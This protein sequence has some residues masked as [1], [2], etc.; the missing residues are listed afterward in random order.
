MKGP[1]QTARRESAYIRRIPIKKVTAWALTGVLFV[2]SPGFSSYQAFAAE[3]SEKP[4]E[5]SSL[6]IP[7]VSVS[8]PSENSAASQDLAIEKIDSLPPSETRL[9]VGRETNIPESKSQEIAAR[10]VQALAPAAGSKSE[11][12][13]SQG[14]RFWGRLS[15]QVFGKSQGSRKIS[16]GVLNRLFDRQKEM[17]TVP[18]SLHSPTTDV[19]SADGGRNIS[20]GISK[21]S[22]KKRLEWVEHIKALPAPFLWKYV[23]GWSIAA[24]GGEMQA[25]ALPVFTAQVFGLSQAIIAAG[26]NLIARIPG[27]WMGAFFVGHFSPKTINNVALIISALSGGL[28]PAALFFHLPHAA[29]FGTFL[30]GSTLSGLVYGA[31]RGVTENLIPPLLISDRTQREFGLN[32][33]YQWVELSSILMAM[34]SVPLL[35]VFGGSVILGISSSFFLIAALFYGS[36]KLHKP[37][38]K[39]PAAVEKQTQEGLSWRSYIPFV[40]FRF[41]HFSLYAVF[42]AAIS[43]GILHDDKMT[44]NIIGAYDFGSWIFGFLATAALLPKKG[45]R[46]WTLAGVGSALAFL[47][48]SS[49]LP[50]PALSMILAGVMG[51][52][53]MINSNKWMSLYQE[54]LP[55]SKLKNLSKWMMTASILGTLPIFI[56]AGLSQVFPAWAAFLTMPHIII[57]A[58]ILVTI[59]GLAALFGFR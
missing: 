26:V 4:P 39:A 44:G 6:Q 11:K 32:Y 27:A 33:A 36:L 21:F 45:E 12:P 42:A 58:N 48:A 31:T 17:G 46:P 2:L 41:I 18:N 40:F 50:I 16:L 53:I 25:V 56:A 15:G 30:L 34:I 55:Q 10:V 9:T 38:A 51:G 43:M 1:E 22:P 7:D 20:L 3:F 47:W 24:M 23:P 14:R 28:V 54:K 37:E 5:V 19:R 13:L 59:L 29:L 35:H 52:M 49:L 57:G 8:I